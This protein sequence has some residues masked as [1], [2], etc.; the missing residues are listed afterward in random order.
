MLILST[1]RRCSTP[2]KDTGWSKSEIRAHL[3]EQLKFLNFTKFHILQNRGVQNSWIWAQFSTRLKFYW[4]IQIL[5]FLR[6]GWSKSFNLSKVFNATQIFLI[7]PK[8]TFSRTGVVKNLKFEYWHS[9]R[10]KFFD[11]AKFHILKEKGSSKMW[12]KSSKIWNMSHISHFAGPGWSKFLNLSTTF[13]AT[14]ISLF[15]KFRVLQDRGPQKSKS[16]I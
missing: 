3:S 4:F 12:K 5:P 8:F 10:L 9:T 16:T 11:F 15:Y 6:P 14:Q 1:C 7:L 13:N 2:L